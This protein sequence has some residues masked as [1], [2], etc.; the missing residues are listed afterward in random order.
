[1]HAWCITRYRS[2][3]SCFLLLSPCFSPFGCVRPTGLRVGRVQD[4]ALLKIDAEGHEDYVLRSAE[5][6]LS[7]RQVDAILVEAKGSGHAARDRVKREYFSR[8]TSGGVGCSYSAYEFY[9]E[10]GRSVYAWNLDEVCDRREA[11]GEEEAVGG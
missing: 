5:S 11:F 3:V 10:V 1:M 2:Y 8:L 9:E 7:K 4:V 6:L